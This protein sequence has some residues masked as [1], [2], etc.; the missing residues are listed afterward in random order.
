M[1]RKISAG[2]LAGVLALSLAACGQNGEGSAESS[3]RASQMYTWVSNESDREQWETFIAGVKEFD[4]PEFELSLEGPS[5][6]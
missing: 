5:F 4:D 1:S 6:Q 3:E 2:L